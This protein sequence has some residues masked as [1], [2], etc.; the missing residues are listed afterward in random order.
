[1]L[2]ADVVRAVEEGRFHVHAVAH[3]DEGIE[4]LTGIPAGTRGDD[5]LYPEGTVNRRIEDRLEAMTRRLAT[6]AREEKG[7]PRPASE[8]TK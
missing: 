8:P 3:V 4:L 2:R 7:E 5:G 1:M 6:L